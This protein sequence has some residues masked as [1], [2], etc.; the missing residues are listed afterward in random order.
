[1][2]GKIWENSINPKMNW[3]YVEQ[4]RQIGPVTEEQ[5]SQLFQ[6]GTI[7]DET[8]VWRAGLAEWQPYNQVRP[9]PEQVAP[10]QVAT[11]NIPDGNE[12]VCA[13]CG[14][15]FPADETIRHVN[16]N[17]CAAC[18]PVFLQKL[19]EGARINTGTLN[20]ASIGS[21]FVAVFLDGLLLLAV[22]FGIGLIAG[23]TAGQAIGVQPKGT[24]MLQIVL[25]AI[26]M[27]I[28]IAYEV[29]LIGKYGA[30]LGKMAMKIK[31]V[32]ADGGR[33][34]YARAAGR[35]FAKMLSAFTCMIGYAIA[36]FDKEKRALHDHICNTR[37]IYK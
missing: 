4:G 17:V 21:R 3:H 23:L 33:V 28:G 10:T 24:V 26:N 22:N 19:A 29:I 9:R 5:L 35:Y 2:V 27:A 18:K 25:T 7:N 16:V 20:L 14:K 31:V 32:I 34:T 8:L 6:A 37:V 36:L 12:V 13:E 15:L 30:T 11:E 1:L